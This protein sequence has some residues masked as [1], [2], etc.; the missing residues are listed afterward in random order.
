MNIKEKLGQ[1]FIIRM[2]EKTIDK[3]LVT[4]IK[5]YHIGGICLYRK[6]Y[7]TYEEMINLINNLKLLNKKYNKTPLFIAID[8][9]GGK[10]NRFPKDIK[11]TLPAKILSKNKEYIKETGNITGELLYKL[12][13]NMNFAP[14]LDIQRFEDSH[15]I[16]NRCFGKNY[17]EVSENGNLMMETLRKN[18][19][20]PVVKHFP[21][22]GT[23]T[24][25]SHIFL[26]ILNKDIDKLED[27]IPFKD[28]INKKVDLIMIS[29]ILITKLDR[30][31]PASLS[32]KVIKDYLI[33]KLNYQ[34]LIITDDI[35]MKAVNILYGYKRSSL[36]AINAGCNIVLI[37]ASYKKVID[38]IE[39][40]KK[41][42][43]SSTINNIENSYN[44]I[45]S[46]KN[47]YNLKDEERE[48]F[49]IEPY[50]KRIDKLNK[51]CLNKEYL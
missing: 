48:I 13:I 31:N 22:H 24:R 39:Y 18:N 8:Q 4:L 34:G 3:Q 9:E 15:P 37:G 26:P 28:S 41:H 19:I 10:V 27:I 32:K 2:H 7:D 40:I 11:N 20:I 51:E 23:V 12:G 29:H 38:S 46:I 6:N 16:G 25:D 45:I 43:N 47:K 30:L 49:D 14:V 36:K 35:K 44:K 33:D 17:K 50:N 42:L 1:L 21:G 5:D